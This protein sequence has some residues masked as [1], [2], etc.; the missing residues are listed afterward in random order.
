MNDQNTEITAE[1]KSAFDFAHGTV[2]LRLRLIGSDEDSSANTTA[3][4]IQMTLLGA[5]ARYIPALTQAVE[6]S[7]QTGTESASGAL[8]Q[9]VE[10]PII[11]G[12]TA[13]VRLTVKLADNAS[14]GEVPFVDLGKGLNDA[15]NDANA[16]I[17]QDEQSQLLAYRS[18]VLSS[19]FGS[20]PYG[21]QCGFA[22]Q[23]VH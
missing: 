5:L 14:L 6:R 16:L 13:R 3:D 15:L 17:R 19:I 10:V 9:R 23:H 8:T 4:L 7:D 20:G 1:R 11:G 22:T 18:A 2:E 21:H 12:F